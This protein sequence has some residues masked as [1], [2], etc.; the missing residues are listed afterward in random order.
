MAELRHDILT[1]PVIRARQLD[2]SEGSFALP[3]VLE[4]LGTEAVA[5]FPGLQPHQFQSWHAFLVQ[6]AAL[7][8]A[9]AGN[10]HPARSAVQWRESLLALTDGQHGPWSLIVDDLSRP[11][12]M[13]APVPE[14][15][16][17]GFKADTGN[18]DAIDILVTSKNHDIKAAR[19]TDPTPEHWIYALVSLQTMQGFSGRD[20][21]G[22]VRMNGGFGNRPSVGYSPSLN[23]GPRFVRDVKVLLRSRDRLVREYGYP[24][25]GGMALLWLEP[26][27]GLGALPIRRCDPFFIEICR[28]VRLVYRGER[29]SAR[30]APSRVKRISSPV[31]SGDTGD[32]W[33]P[34]KTAAREA[35]TLDGSGFTYRRIQRLLSSEFQLGAAASVQPDDPD[36][37]YL[38]AR[39]LVRGQGKTDGLHD[40]TIPIP[41]SA[42][43]ILANPEGAERLQALAA[44]RVELTALVDRSILHP[45]L[46]VLLQGGPEK[47]KF[48]D[49]RTRRWR[50][51]FDGD[52]DAGF[53]PALWD[54]AELTPADADLRWGERL[55]ELSSAQLRE[56][57]R[58]APPSSARHYRAV[59]AAERVFHGAFR[60]LFPD[61]YTTR[62]EEN[63]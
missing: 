46:C 5:G 15:S 50:D 49:K 58:S 10:G 26:W 22:I 11:A 61:M 39:G 6:T 54:D 17:S 8:L 28:R 62:D 29:V 14:D 40:R 1:E 63:G 36:T 53:F 20:N 23:A 60:R 37:L 16:L 4:M 19:I 13:Q 41:R 12:F 56:A 48:D 34:V 47:A 44:R 27:D 43:K 51:T 38:I 55:R 30:T 18:P 33:T 9:R 45:A 35:L 42:R 3:D 25:S 32:V 2:G 52:V 7:A 31:D 57:I 24:Q 59:A 21:Y